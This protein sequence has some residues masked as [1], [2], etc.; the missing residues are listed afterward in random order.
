MAATDD[1]DRAAH[2]RSSTETTELR[3]ECPK[4]IVNV[5]DAVSMAKP[6]Q[7]NRTSLINEILGKWAEEKLHEASL[8]QRLAGGNPNRPETGGGNLS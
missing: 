3:G 7:R 6:S 8:I 1:Y 4:W 5:L 2:A